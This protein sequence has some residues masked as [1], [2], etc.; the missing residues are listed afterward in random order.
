MIIKHFNYA[1][2]NIPFTM[3]V[4]CVSWCLITVECH[5]PVQWHLADTL[6]LSVD[7]TWHL[8]SPNM[9]PAPT[10]TDMANTDNMGILHHL[11]WQVL[12]SK[13]RCVPQHLIAKDD[14][15]FHITIDI[16]SPLIK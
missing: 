12:L 11:Q 8:Q 9:V 4:T 14:C 6:C 16:M 13:S 10:A 2:H 1:F 15:T 3:I 5:P 7:D